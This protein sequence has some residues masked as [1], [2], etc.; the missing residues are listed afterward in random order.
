VAPLI[1]LAVSVA[2]FW[3][4]GHA[5]LMVFQDP[6]FVLRSALAVMFLLTASA[7][8]GRRRVD[9]VRMV[10][11]SIPK[12]EALVTIT[13]VLEL[14]GAIG[15]LLPSTGRA[16]CLWLIALLVALFPANVRAAREHLTIAGRP[17]PGLL[18]RGAIQ[19]VF[20]ATLIAAAW[21]R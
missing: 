8:W 15:L 3:I 18:A 4:S 9:L 11:P 7:H 21:I 6:S 13:G 14:L 1:V 19:L 16:T 12:P 5:G 2:V 10:P 20:I 17:V